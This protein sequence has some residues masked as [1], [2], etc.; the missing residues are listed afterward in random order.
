MIIKAS[1]ILI[2]L[3]ILK[4][5]YLIPNRLHAE[6][7]G[8]SEIKTWSNFVLRITKY[9]TQIYLMLNRKHFISNDEEQIFCT[10]NSNKESEPFYYP[11]DSMSTIHESQKTK[12]SNSTNIIHINPNKRHGRCSE[13]FITKIEHIVSTNTTKI[14][15]SYLK[16]PNKSG[17]SGGI[18]LNLKDLEKNKKYY[19]ISSTVKPLDFTLDPNHM[20]ISDTLSNQKTEFKFKNLK[21]N[22]LKTKAYCLKKFYCDFFDYEISELKESTLKNINLKYPKI[23]S[24]DSKDSKMMLMNN[25]QNNNIILRKNFTKTRKSKAFDYIYHKEHFLN[26][27]KRQTECCRT[28][29]TEYLHEN[30]GI[31]ESRKS[32]ALEDNENFLYMTD[33]IN[34]NIDLS[35][36]CKTE[37][38]L[39]NSKVQSNSAGNKV[40]IENNFKIKKYLERASNEIAELS[41]I[42]EELKDLIQKIN[43]GIDYGKNK[44]NCGT[45]NTMKIEHK[46]PKNPPPQNSDYIINKDHVKEYNDYQNKNNHDKVK[47]S[48]IESNKN[49][50][51]ADFVKKGNYSEN[52]LEK[53]ISRCEQQFLQNS[54]SQYYLDEKQIIT[55]PYKLTNYC[56]TFLN[57]F[58]EKIRKIEEFI[59][60]QPKEKKNF[61]IFKKCKDMRERPILT[62]ILQKFA[63]IIMMD[64]I[65]RIDKHSK[66]RNYFFLSF[67]NQTRFI[68]FIKTLKKDIIYF[69]NKIS[70]KW[71]MQSQAKEYHEVDAN[72]TVRYA[73]YCETNISLNDIGTIWHIYKSNRLLKDTL[74]KYTVM[75]ILNNNDWNKILE[76]N[77]QYDG[78]Y[79]LDMKA[80]F[81][82]QNELFIP[83]IINIE[84]DKT[85]IF[86]LEKTLFFSS[87]EYT[88]DTTYFK[89]DTPVLKIQLKFKIGKI[90]NNKLTINVLNR[91]T[92]KKY[93]FYFYFSKYYLSDVYLN[94]IKIIYYDKI[95]DEV[96]SN[97]VKIND[98]PIANLS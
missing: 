39:S 52:S 97:I 12:I 73:L 95:E 1:Q 53:K 9:N 70:Y 77:I 46:N 20:A 50:V 18:I 92:D 85:R 44:S 8:E 78:I 67:K 24:A 76:S 6:A 38:Y 11:R 15:F 91:I 40:K 16:T 80:P 30:C 5:Y 79:T 58:I 75:C 48:E 23:A 66:D 93:K 62:E 57:P 84:N 17:L 3:F 13:M 49:P 22:I 86:K 82:S 31:S 26:N 87:I 83:Y 71:L 7:S 69:T 25:L 43:S 88:D 54:V 60:D 90:K 33:K 10:N 55:P 47:F 61:N 74:K 34:K 14:L 94:N 28:S 21:N 29:G 51:L 64:Y 56:Y 98:D 36:E 63:N 19:L 68:N 32:L 81:C 35:L 4:N 65:Q 59:K 2:L 37:N 96:F 27:I 42:S 45:E 89:A 41:E 72:K